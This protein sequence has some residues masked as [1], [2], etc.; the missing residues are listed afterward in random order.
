MANFLVYE[1][2]I[3]AKPRMT[4]RDKFLIPPRK[5]VA[6]YWA[7]KNL[8]NFAANKRGFT[9]GESFYVNFEIG[10]P[11]SW[12]EKKKKKMLGQPHKSRPD[13][14]NFLK[15]ICDCLLAED[16]GVW[17]VTAEKVWAAKSRILIQNL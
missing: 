16:S 8:L 4:R 15:G 10:M 17:K 5:C 12:S 1:G 13:L 11:E 14:D 7:F 3:V 2:P 6:S 9:L